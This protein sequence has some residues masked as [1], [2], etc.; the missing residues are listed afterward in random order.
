MIKTYNGKRGY[1]SKRG[2]SGYKVWVV[3]EDEVGPEKPPKP[4][5]FIVLSLLMVYAGVQ[6]LIQGH[7]VVGSFMVAYPLI[8][9]LGLKD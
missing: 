3:I 9:W 2:N 1:W 4:Y 8:M 6:A 5:A 7:W